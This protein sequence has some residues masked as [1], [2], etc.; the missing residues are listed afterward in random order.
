MKQITRY[1]GFT[2]TRSTLLCMALLLGVES[3]FI[4]VNEIRYV[5]T[6]DYTIGRA[7]LFYLCSVPQNI[8]LMFPMSALVGTLMGLGVLASRSE[9]IVLQAAGLS[10]ANI[11]KIV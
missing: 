6:G 4:L 9:L 11:T 8:Y 3:I 2:I 10:L 5:G 1:I 7:F